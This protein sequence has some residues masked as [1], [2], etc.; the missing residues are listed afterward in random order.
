MTIGGRP[1]VLGA[2][3]LACLAPA[4][5]PAA[6]AQSADKPVQLKLS[7]WVPPTHPLQAAIQDWADSI[8]KDSHGTITSV[9]FPAEQ[10]GKAFDHYDMA[11]DGI[12]DVAYINPGYQPGRFPMIAAGDLPFTVR[13]ASTG[14]CGDRRL[15]SQIRR[16]RDAGREILLRLHPRSG[17]AAHQAARRGAGRRQGHEAAPRGRHDGHLDD[18]A[19]RQQR[20]GV[21]PRLARPAGARGGQGIFFPWGSLVLF[22]IDKVTKYHI[23][24]AMYVSTFVW[25]LNKA[26][27]KGMSPDQKK[28]ID[29][30]CNDRMGGALR[31]PLGRFRA[32][33]IAK[34]ERRA[35]P[36]ADRTDAGTARGME[37]VGRPLHA[38]LGRGVKR[39]ASIRTR[40]MRSFRPRLQAPRRLLIRRCRVRRS[41]TV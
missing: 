38:G 12:A 16:A 8:K 35:G 1:C 5:V 9:I 41:P 6:R 36:G 31:R 26:R 30:H 39:A 13:R 17:D 28:V 7:H 11:R 4:L 24:A 34:I 40:S 10:L 2:L 15:V 18:A 27:Y 32:C 23:D 25:V 14:T 20:A 33:R 29:N 21:G 3:L 22:G 19:R 37:A